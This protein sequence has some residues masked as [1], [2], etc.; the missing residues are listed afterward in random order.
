VLGRGTDVSYPWCLSDGKGSAVVGTATAEEEV[1]LMALGHGIEISY[2]C[3]LLV[4]NGRELV[5][6]DGADL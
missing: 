5:A 4:L 3:W 6:T 1:L 2:P